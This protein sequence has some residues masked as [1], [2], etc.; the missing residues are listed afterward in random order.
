LKALEWAL[1]RI[2]VGVFIG[3]S[4]GNRFSEA[5]S[6]GF[7]KLSSVCCSRFVDSNLDFSEGLKLDFVALLRIR[8]SAIVVFA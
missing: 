3:F 6:F 7:V 4:D 2:G 8:R 5:R 1:G